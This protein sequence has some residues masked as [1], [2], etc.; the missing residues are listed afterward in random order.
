M[1]EVGR[2][3]LKYEFSVGVSKGLDRT[4]GSETEDFWVWQDV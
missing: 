2:M 4:L 3:C 1:A